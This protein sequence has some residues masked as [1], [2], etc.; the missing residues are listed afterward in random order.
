MNCRDIGNDPGRP[1][2][3]R[4]PLSQETCQHQVALTLVQEVIGALFFRLSGTGGGGRIGS[5]R[6][7][8]RSCI[9][10]RRLFAADEGTAWAL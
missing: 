7:R 1:Y 3:E 2:V 5:C 6:G 9:D 10:T 8:L 4:R